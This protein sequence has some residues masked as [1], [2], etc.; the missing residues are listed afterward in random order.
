MD[1]VLAL[2]PAKSC[3]RTVAQAGYARGTW[4]ALQRNG[5]DQRIVSLVDAFREN[6]LHHVS[7]KMKPLVVRFSN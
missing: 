1:L 5:R 7:V 3:G 4:P 2:D 6:L